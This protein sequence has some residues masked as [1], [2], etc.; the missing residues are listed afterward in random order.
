MCKVKSS[1]R[2]LCSRLRRHL[3][4]N[5]SCCALGHPDFLGEAQ[6]RLS[7]QVR[8]AA[9]AI[10]VWLTVKRNAWQPTWSSFRQPLEP[11]YEDTIISASAQWERERLA[12]NTQLKMKLE[13]RCQRQIDSGITCG[14]KPWNQ[15]G[16]K[17]KL[18]LPLIQE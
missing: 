10:E 14:D 2:R 5:T 6:L 9:D 8:N 16:S 12:R 15:A 13:N 4:I 1:R 18:Y 11:I 17:T 3:F 7:A